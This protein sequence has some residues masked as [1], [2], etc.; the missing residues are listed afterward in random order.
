ETLQSNCEVTGDCADYQKLPHT[1]TEYR[2]VFAR[3]LDQQLAEFNSAI[4]FTVLAKGDP[5][6]RIANIL[7]EHALRVLARADFFTSAMLGSFG[8]RGRVISMG[9]GFRSEERRVGK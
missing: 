7:P 5:H 6:R 4:E 3:Y 2:E 8:L 9:D 1:A